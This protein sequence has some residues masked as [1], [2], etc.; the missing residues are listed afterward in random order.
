MSKTNNIILIKQLNSFH[1]YL[2]FALITF[3]N[4]Y[5]LILS[6]SIKIIE[7]YTILRDKIWHNLIF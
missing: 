4:Y 6:N 2:F 1:Q 3:I 5:P 7:K